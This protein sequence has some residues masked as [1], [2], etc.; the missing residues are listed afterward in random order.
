[1]LNI[2]CSVTSRMKDRRFSCHIV[3]HPIPRRRTNCDESVF[4]NTFI[5]KGSTIL[6]ILG[7]RVRVPLA[8]PFI[9]NR[10]S[11]VRLPFP[12]VGNDEGW[13]PSESS[14]RLVGGLVPDSLTGNSGPVGVG[15]HGVDA[16]G[17]EGPG[18]HG[19]ES[20]DRYIS[21]TLLRGIKDEMPSFKRKLGSAEILKLT[22]NIRS[23]R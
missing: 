8:A 21:N 2:P 15:C 23:L 17:D 1:M 7:S 3:T 22:V 13:L 6:W 5:R 14:L 9:I 16:S 12:W 19:L 20:S 11:R 4:R 18:V 10:N